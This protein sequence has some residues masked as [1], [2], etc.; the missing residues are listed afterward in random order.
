MIEQTAIVP[1][2]IPSRT[3]THKPLERC[4]KDMLDQIL[5]KKIKKLLQNRSDL[6]KH[7]QKLSQMKKEVLQET[8]AFK[9]QKNM[10]DLEEQATEMFTRKLHDL[11]E[12]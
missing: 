12:T 7:A 8:F 5:R 1:E 10:D 11:T 6:G 2:I 3:T 4:E 9:P